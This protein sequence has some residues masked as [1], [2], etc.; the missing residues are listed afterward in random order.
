MI[1]TTTL[2]NRLKQAQSEE[3]VKD[4]HIKALK[5]SGMMAVFRHQF[6][7][8]GDR[9]PYHQNQPHQ[10]A[11]NCQSLRHLPAFYVLL[12]MLLFQ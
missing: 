6:F 7:N 12:I 3:D 1:V 9:F 11:G 4:I 2:Y 10:F 5:H 8:E